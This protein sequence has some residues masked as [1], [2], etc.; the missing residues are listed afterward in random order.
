MDNGELEQL[1]NRVKECKKC[2]LSETR[3]NAAPGEGSENSKIMFLGE[4]PGRVEDETGRPFVGRCGQLLTKLIESIGLEREN[5]FITSPVKCR[6][7]N[8]RRPKKSEI[9]SCIT[10]L[11]RQI[12]IIKPE[13]IVLLGNTAIETML[14]KMD[15]INKLHGKTINRDGRIYFLTFHPAAGIRATGNKIKLEE[16]FKK[17]Q[18]II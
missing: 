3:K 16:D 13:I 7:P 15:G 2:E 14:G 18:K 4:A 6:P 17:L 10:Y 9:C 8:N 12:E 5:V 1:H 11:D